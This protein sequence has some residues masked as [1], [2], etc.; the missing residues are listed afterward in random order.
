MLDFYLGQIRWNLNTDT[1][2]FDWSTV[3]QAMNECGFQTKTWEIFKDYNVK[4]IWIHFNYNKNNEEKRRGE[5][6]K[7]S[8]RVLMLEK[9][10]NRAF[11]SQNNKL[12]KKLFH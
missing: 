9:E 7:R 11:K 6:T 8:Q 1:K 12:A 4:T 5:I 2:S 10:I 3:T